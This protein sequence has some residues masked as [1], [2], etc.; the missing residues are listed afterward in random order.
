MS[1]S[2]FQSVRKSLLRALFLGV[3]GLGIGSALGF[4]AAPA[5]VRAD[6]GCTC[7]VD[8]SVIGSYDCATTTSSSC[9]PGSIKCTTTCAE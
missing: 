7:T 3:A 4:V 6:P 5:A 2:R 8:R 9:E 1:Q